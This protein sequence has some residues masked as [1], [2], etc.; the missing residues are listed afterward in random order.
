MDNQL[1]S[2]CDRVEKVISSLGWQFCFIGGVAIQRWGEPRFTADVDLTLLT[3][4]CEEEKFITELLLRFK[5]RR[6]DAL[7]FA[8]TY[9]VL[10]L[11]DSNGVAIDISLGALPF[12]E[13]SISR[14]SKYSFSPTI[15]LTTCSAEDL[16]T[17]KAF[18]GRDK[19]WADVETIL[20]KN[21][22]K[23]DLNL[24]RSELIELAELK[25]EPEIME[26][27]EKKIESIE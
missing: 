26:R 6:E 22:K 18:A 17:H 7:E 2:T 11:E 12:E 16:I 9:R 24:V 10:L 25:E 8:L 19:D 15:T 1:L 23:L 4:F 3:G 14:S 5:P 20:R 21:F 13:R 27:L